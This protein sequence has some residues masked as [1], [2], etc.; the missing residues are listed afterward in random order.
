MGKFYPLHSGHIG[1]IEFAQNQCDELVV[2]VCASDSETIAGS[3]RLQWLKETFIQEPKIKPILF[4]YSEGHLP[5][6]SISSKSVSEIWAF[7]I[8]K[9]LNQVDIIFSSEIYGDYLADLLHCRHLIFQPERITSKISST[10]IRENPFKYWDYLAYSARPYFV[11]KICLYGTESTGKSTLTKKLA[12]HFHTD[13][14][15]EMARE[16]IEK[17]DECTE[18]HLVQIAELHA[19]AIK[20]KLKTANKIL[21]V[22]TDLNITRSYSKFLFSNQLKVQDWVEEVNQFDI[23]LYLD[24]DAPHI[25][26]GTRLDE[27]Q[28]NKLDVYHKNEL[29]DRAINFELVSGNWH[30][31]FEKAVS[32]IEDFLAFKNKE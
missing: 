27:Q 25:Q 21:F 22:D 8:K 5:N 3:I 1:L 14:V 11:K 17:T 32:I 19:L 24:N 6:T 30:Q 29:T 28:R 2:L 15:P 9:I 10:Q 7:E 20:K 12:A 4:N 31:R 16:I 13:F 18:K 23:Y 26:D